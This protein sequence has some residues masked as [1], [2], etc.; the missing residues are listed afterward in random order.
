MRMNLSGPICQL[1]AKHPKSNCHYLGPFSDLD[2][3]LSGYVRYDELEDVRENY[4]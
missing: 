3:D 1:M 2:S 4:G